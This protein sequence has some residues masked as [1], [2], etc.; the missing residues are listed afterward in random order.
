[1]KKIVSLIAALSVTITVCAQSA[2]DRL[3]GTYFINHDGEKSKVLFTK[4]KDNTYKCQVI[5]LADAKDEKGNLRL[6]RKNPDEKKRHVPTNQ[7]VLIDKITYKDG[8]WKDG[9]IYDPTRGL[10]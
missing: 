3:I 1:M 7:V 4:I 6:D 2:G 9:K 8:I 5:W 10:L